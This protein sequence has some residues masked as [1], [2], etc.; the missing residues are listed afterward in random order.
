[1]NKKVKENKKSETHNNIMENVEEN[2]PLP[3]RKMMNSYRIQK[4]NDRNIGDTGNELDRKRNKLILYNITESI[5]EEI[6][7]KYNLNIL[8]LDI[9]SYGKIT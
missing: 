9:N 1:M 6:K 2:N 8:N 5:N 4:D 3:E 7:E